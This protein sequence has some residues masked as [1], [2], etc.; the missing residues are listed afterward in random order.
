MG[1]QS[2]D[3][4]AKVL[5]VRGRHQAEA[6]ARAERMAWNLRVMKEAAQGPQP[7]GEGYSF[8]ELNGAADLSHAEDAEG[9]EIA[10]NADALNFIGELN[11]V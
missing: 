6:E 9:A 4:A 11:A 3:L 10:D 7:T 5:P 2:A 1:E 8:E